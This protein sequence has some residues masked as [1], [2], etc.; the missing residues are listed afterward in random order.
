MVWLR[1]CTIGL[2]LGLL[3]ACSS[4]KEACEAGYSSTEL[5]VATYQ[6]VTTT[7]TGIG[8]APTSNGGAV[9]V[10][11]VS[12]STNYSVLANNGLTYVMDTEPLSGRITVERCGA[13]IEA[14]A[15]LT[16]WQSTIQTILSVIG[17]II[18]GIATLVV[19]GMLAG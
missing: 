18:I 1:L 15:V 7:S 16:P 10:A 14:S 19:I 12:S 8:I 4:F 17:W 9:P 5:T 6:A 13:R 2:S 3:S 11:T